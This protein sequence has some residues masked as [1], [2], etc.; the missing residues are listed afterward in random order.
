MIMIIHSVFPE[1]GA[2]LPFTELVRS[3]GIKCQKYVD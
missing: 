2:A 1:A 3:G